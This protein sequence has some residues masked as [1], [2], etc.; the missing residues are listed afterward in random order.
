MSDIIPAFHSVI[1]GLHIGLGFLGLGLF[2]GIVAIPKGTSLHRRLGRAFALITWIVGGSALFSS[3][4]ALMD[5]SSFTAGESRSGDPLARRQ[6]YE[7]IFFILLYLSAGTISGAVFGVQL[8]R[9]K[10]RHEELRRTTLPFWLLITAASAMGLITFGVANLIKSAP[11]G[12]PG[13]AYWVPVVVGLAGLWSV[14]SEWSYVFGPV[15]AAGTWIYEHVRHMCGTGIAFHT[16]FL[17]F[18][19]N[20]LLGFR[21]PGAWALLPWV[22]PPVIGLMLTSR[23]V[24]RLKQNSIVLEG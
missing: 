2:W 1:R 5:L 16:A 11:E 17:V 19:A 6:I 4:W 14:W 12:M 21:L 13:Q 24:Q 15:P 9:T 23:Y 10:E 7:F 22:I 8:V 20:R 3:V 18:G